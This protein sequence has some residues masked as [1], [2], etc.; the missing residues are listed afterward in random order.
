MRRRADRMAM[1]ML[2]SDQ[3]TDAL[4]TLRAAR[5]VYRSRPTPENRIALSTR[6]QKLDELLDNYNKERAASCLR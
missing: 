2:I 1:L 6:Q 5:K 3:I 4:T